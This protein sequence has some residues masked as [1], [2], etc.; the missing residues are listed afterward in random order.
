M[1]DEQKLRERYLQSFQFKLDAA[2]MVP[3]DVF[4]VALG[5]TFPEIR[6]NKLLRFNRSVLTKPHKTWSDPSPT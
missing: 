2:S 1:K 3:T 4:Y 5:V 6:L